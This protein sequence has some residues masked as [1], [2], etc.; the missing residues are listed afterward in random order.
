MP[1]T[2]TRESYG[3]LTKLFHWTTALLIL[4]LIPLGL[5]AENLPQE[6]G[7]EIA[8]KAQLFSVH[9][10]LGIATFAVALLRILWAL[11]RP[12]PAPL[13]PERRAETLLAETAHWTLYAALVVVPLSGWIHHAASAGF[14]PIL[15]P[16][17]Q[18]LPFV[19]RSDLVFAVA[20][21][22]HWVF[23]KVLIAALLLHV[24][25]A[26][27][28]AFIDRDGTLRRMWFGPFR[29]APDGRAPHRT[30]FALPAAAA[31]YVAGGVAVYTLTAPVASPP[32]PAA[33]ASAETAGWRVEEG[34][35]GIDVSQFGTS[36]EGSFAAW[37][38]DIDFDPETGTGD[39]RV[40]VAID[41]LT[42]GS[43]TEQALGPDYFA[44]ET[45]PTSIFEATI[46][47][48]EEGYLAEGTL[49]LAGE[50]VP[51]R[52]PFTLGIAD[53]TAEM[54]GET[55]LD[56]RDFGIGDATTDP[57]TLGFDVTVVIALTATRQE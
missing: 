47:P 32:E 41:S 18:G 48:A 6:T 15:W 35:I 29:A 57:D 43:V 12:K 46:S 37:S 16:F 55:I 17:G 13:H 50:T 40:E 39:V 30:G 5:V 34:R 20:G 26:L 25:G 36:V 7:A 11:V 52:L 14:A 27:K 2:D 22:T 33:P 56:R 51:V 44:A 24:A 8:R 10:T 54:R 23:T 28:H 42:L 53:G 31:I 38:A 3:T 19:P 9:K 4:A 21:T 1:T 45:H 49:S